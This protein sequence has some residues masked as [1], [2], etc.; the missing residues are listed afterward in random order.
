MHS[1]PHA[2]TAFRPLVREGLALPTRR[3][4]LKAGLA[5]VAGLS[6]PGLLRAQAEAA[7]A[8]RRG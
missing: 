3:N 1:H 6:L 4:L 2:F 5:G 7:S 8:A